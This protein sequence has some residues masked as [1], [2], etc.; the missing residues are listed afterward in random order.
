MP[1][2]EGEGLR[3]ERR[4]H[5]TNATNYPPKC[6]QEEDQEGSNTT[7]GVFLPLPPEWDW[8]PR[9]LRMHNA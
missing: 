5:A 9:V 4:D 3:W 8:A 2:G 1:R 6:V 7:G